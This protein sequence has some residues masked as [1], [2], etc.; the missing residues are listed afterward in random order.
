MR[1]VV[2]ILVDY[3]KDFR[4]LL[5][6]IVA[7]AVVLALEFCGE[8]GEIVGNFLGLLVGVYFLMIVM[9]AVYKCRYCFK[10]KCLRCKNYEYCRLNEK[11]QSMCNMCYKMGGG[12][13]E[14]IDFERTGKKS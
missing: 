1:K 5:V 11:S 9:K 14:C 10:C 4:S 6:L 2:K 7:T 3:V 13:K 12:V 8:T